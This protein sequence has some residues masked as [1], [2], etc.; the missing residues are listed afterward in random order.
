MMQSMLVHM[1]L[2]PS[3]P[4]KTRTDGVTAVGH[5]L[6]DT[7]FYMGQVK[8]GPRVCYDVAVY[9]LP[10]HKNVKWVPIASSWTMDKNIQN[11]KR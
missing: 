9:G 1:S 5:G 3:T 11:F 2:D 10:A 7:S 6:R 4:L 8:E